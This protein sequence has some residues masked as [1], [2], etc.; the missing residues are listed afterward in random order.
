MFDLS[1]SGDSVGHMAQWWLDFRRFNDWLSL[2]D[3]PV[4]SIDQTTLP[5][6]VA[7]LQEILLNQSKPLEERNK[8]AILMTGEISGARL[9]ISLATDEKLPDV[10]METIA[11]SMLN[12]ANREVRS[13]SQGVFENPLSA[14]L[15][16]KDVAKLSGNPNHG[17]PIFDAKCSTCHQI[18]NKGQ[19]I[20][21]NLSHIGGKFDIFGLLDALI[22]PSASI[23]F[24]YQQTIIKTV[25]DQVFNGFLLSRNKSSVV[26]RDISGNRQVIPLEMI[27][28]EQLLQNSIMPDPVSL[29][30]DEQSLA[31]LTAYLLTLK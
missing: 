6:N 29:G 13:M 7:A 2:W 21:P 22:N 26:L 15:A 31:D 12:H 1:A 18:G 25:D 11:L 14:S 19:N 16:I 20:G 24:G 10:V 28:S 9:L 4:P 17:K 23:G 27:S 5:D 3:W 8:A 30:M